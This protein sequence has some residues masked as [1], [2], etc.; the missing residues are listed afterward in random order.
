MRDRVFNPAV[1]VTPRRVQ[2][3][4]SPI[5]L[6]NLLQHLVRAAVLPQAASRILDAGGPEYLSY[7]GMMRQFGAVIGSRP[8]IIPV[9]VLASRLSSNWLA[10]VTTVAA[11]IARAPIGGLKHDIPADDAQLRALLPQPLA[12]FT[13]SVQAARRPRSG[14][15]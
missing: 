11:N 7:Q 13:E 14:T 10:L 1:M 9:P 4:S 6:A 12:T 5:A 3:R 2:S 15:R 8:R